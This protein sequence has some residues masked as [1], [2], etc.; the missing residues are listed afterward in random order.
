MC[1]SEGTNRASSGRLIALG[2]IVG[3]HGVHGLLRFHPYNHRADPAALAVDHPV[4]LTPRTAPA[5]EPR[6]V[7]LR[8]ARP[9][10][11]VV[12]LQLAGVD[13]IEDAEPLVGSVLAVPAASLPPPAPGEFYAYQL[14]GLE[15]LTVGGDR[16]GTVDALFPT[17]SN[18]VLVVRD[19]AREHLIPVIADVVR[20]VDL[21][22]GRV[23]IEP[24]EGLLE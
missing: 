6:P 11:R 19:G 22:A 16:L 15:V 5:A 4:F 13:R 20:E 21:A 24:L 7:M 10:G 9:H 8:T 17:G 23:V 12:L 14:E 2:E 3:T 1:M 18:D